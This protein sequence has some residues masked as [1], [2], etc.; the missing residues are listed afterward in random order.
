MPEYGT[1]DFSHVTGLFNIMKK[2]SGD[3]FWLLGLRIVLPCVSCKHIFLKPWGL[4][5]IARGTGL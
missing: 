1:M 4:Q 5:T 2:K 3:F